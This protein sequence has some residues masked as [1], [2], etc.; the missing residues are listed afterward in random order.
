MLFG[1]HFKPLIAMIL[2][3]KHMSYIILF[4]TS[5]KALPLLLNM[6]TS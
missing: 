4:A 1:L 3:N 6:L 5:R 2:M